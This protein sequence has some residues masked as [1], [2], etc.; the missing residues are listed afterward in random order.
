MEKANNLVSKKI[1]EF[2]SN[3][4]SVEVSPEIIPAIIG[5]GGSKIESLQQLGGGAVVDADKTAGMVKIYSRDASSRE[6]VQT[7][8]Q[9]IIDENQVGFV[10]NIEK[11]SLGFLFGD[12]G[13]E[14][15]AAVAELKCNVQV[16]EEE[17]KL[18]VRG[19]KEN[20][21]KACEVL[22]EFMNKNY[23][24][25]LDIHAEDEILLFSGVEKSLLHTVKSRYDV[26]ALFRKDRGVLQIRGEVDKVEAAKKEVEEFLYGGEGITVIKFKVPED[27]I[28][29]IVGKG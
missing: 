3:I 29:S 22:K 9:Q 13:K 14:T 12:P 25:E 26:K 2:E 21:A 27:A 19:T 4:V 11:K 23:V 8:V 1:K 5:K 17:S 7:A 20:I 28:G 15:M 16:S 18:T 6:A 10:D 24:L